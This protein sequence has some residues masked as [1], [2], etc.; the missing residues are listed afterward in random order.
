M[1]VL[2]AN[3]MFTCLTLYTRYT[4]YDPVTKTKRNVLGEKTF[5][6]AL[7]LRY[8]KYSGRDS[9]VVDA[10]MRHNIVRFTAISLCG[11][12]YDMTM[13]SSIGNINRSDLWTEFSFPDITRRLIIKRL[14][15]NKKPLIYPL[16][17]T[18]K[19]SLEI[20]YQKYHLRYVVTL[21]S[22]KHPESKYWSDALKPRY[23]KI[24]SSE[25]Y[26]LWLI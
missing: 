7:W 5:S 3:V 19:S 4:N 2:L 21:N 16:D 11:S 20:H 15:V 6:S 8:N 22:Y 12:V 14:Y 18:N 13:Q 25:G 9:L 17:V 24:F 10:N 1:L 23:W 26:F